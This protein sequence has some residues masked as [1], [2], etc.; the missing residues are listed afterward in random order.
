M[1]EDHTGNASI[2][3][4]ATSAAGFVS[5]GQARIQVLDENGNWQDVTSVGQDGIIDFAWIVGSNS[6]TVTLDDLPAG[7]YRVVGRATG[8]NFLTST[9]VSAE[10][11]LYDHSTV[12]GYEPGT[13]SGNVIDEND[14]VT[15]TTEVTEVNGV[16]VGGA[17]TTPIVGTYGTLTID[18][19]GNYSYTPNAD[20]AGI[21]QVDV[22]EY[23]ITD[24]DGNTDT[25]TLYVRIDSEGQG[26][27]WPS[28]PTLPAEIEMV[29]NDDSGSAVIDSANVIEAGGPTGSGTA[30]ISGGLGGTSATVTRTFIV[31][32][33]DEASIRFV[34]GSPDEALQSDT[35]TLV[36]TGDNG[37]S[38]TLTGTSGFLSGL[39]VDQVLSGLPAGNY[40]VTATYSRPGASLLG[41]EL[42]LEFTGQS[43]THLDEY[44][45]ADTDPAE[46]NVLTDDT[47]GSPYTV[48]KID[49]G[50]GTFVEVTNGTI[51]NGEY[52]TLT[53]NA[54]GSYSY[55]PNPD[56]QGI[57][58]TDEFTYRLEHPNGTVE[59]ATLAVSVGHGD[60]PY[61]PP[62]DPGAPE[63]SEESIVPDLP[64]TEDGE[65]GPDWEVAWTADHEYGNT[66]SFLWTD[67][68]DIADG[69]LGV[70]QDA[71]GAIAIRMTGGLPEG[72]IADG[73]LVKLKVDWDNA[74]V[75][76]GNPENGDPNVLQIVIG[77]VLYATVT[78]PESGSPAGTP[79]AVEYFNGAT[80]NLASVEASSFD[81]DGV[82]D[83]FQQDYDWTDW[84]IELP[85]IAGAPEVIIRWD[86]TEDR[87]VNVADDIYIRDFGIYPAEGGVEVAS[88]E[89]STTFSDDVIALDHLD[90]G[91]SDVDASS[92][93]FPESSLSDNFV[94]DDGEETDLSVSLD[95]FLGDAE[96]SANDPS[97]ADRDYQE[98]ETSPH[99]PAL[100]GDVD[101]FAYLQTS[102]VDDPEQSLS[103]HQS[104]M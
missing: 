35:L 15:P 36:I 63:Y 56:L 97:F 88:A 7:E 49:T 46:G 99:T 101:P 68:E 41:G 82:T 91:N 104:V 76:A 3:I 9:T 48:F 11:D 71:E 12:G 73:A 69:V 26:L 20:G 84:E 94:L 62:V 38:Q 29:A 37:Y 96:Q 16:A 43:I 61:V 103:T 93:E 102:S 22:F 4:G 100:E 66:G 2:T 8:I 85:P 23:T 75:G 53:I 30:S 5:G 81:G 74:F 89:I 13:V 42:S 52:G 51:V 78:T 57:G 54:D 79:A 90:D 50:D 44:V 77:G 98:T 64:V 67:N 24:A 86:L 1:P 45:V 21:G 27:V 18:A 59:D 70:S 95:A 87:T 14:T 40:T 34:A 83:P 33:N 60:G 25:A 72:S 39:G 92:I 80:G 31:D 28:D 32:A 10:V 65:F 55:A 47:I 17:G 19:E 58:G 6:A